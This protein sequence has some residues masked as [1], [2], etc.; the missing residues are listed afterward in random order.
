M[1]L[2]NIFTKEVYRPISD[3]ARPERSGD[4]ERAYRRF[5]GWLEG[6]HS[7]DNKEKLIVKL[8]QSGYHAGRNI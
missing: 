3:S 4:E 5:G 1:F 7:T 2:R 8:E 6:L